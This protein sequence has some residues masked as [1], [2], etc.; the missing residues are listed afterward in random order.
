[1]QGI[2]GIMYINLDERTERREM[3]EGE[4]DRLNLPKG[5]IYRLS[6]THDR[7]N[8]VRGCLLS[9]IRALEMVQEKGWKNALILEDDILFMSDREEI[10][11]SLERFYSSAKEDW[12]V[13]FLGGI[14]VEKEKTGW[15]GVIRI[16]QSL[17]SHAYIIQ[18]SYIPKLKECF[19]CAVEMIKNDLFRFHSTKYAL[20][21]VWAPLQKQDRWYALEKQ[22]ILQRMI[23]S[24]IDIVSIPMNRFDE[25]I[26]IDTGNKEALREE[27]LR[28][29]VSIE[30]LHWA[31]SYQ[32]AMQLAKNLKGRRFFFVEDTTKFP[33]NGDELDLHFLHF[34]RWRARE[35][36]LFLIESN[37]CEKIPSEHF[38][39]QKVTKIFS[40]KCFVA[41]DLI[42]GAL[43]DHFDKGKGLDTLEIKPEMSVF[44]SP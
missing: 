26:C 6:A 36:D 10:E 5:K 22:R 15:E 20:D 16:H 24:D 19:S 35:W 31:S 8:G 7:L 2:D 21:R 12:D 42:L 17:C 38:F 28:F 14:F 41:S 13:I 40:P 23:P 32:E 29:G 3:L 44:C 25:V 18:S 4:V 39:F 30:D 11:S 33:Q 1:M 43:L 37:Q 27:F 9:H 34:F